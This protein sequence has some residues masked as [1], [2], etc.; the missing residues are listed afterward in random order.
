MAEDRKL[1]VPVYLNQ[2]I[3]FDMLAMLQ[4]GISTVTSVS[5]TE[6]SADEKSRKM[7]GSFGLSQALSS[8]LKIDLSADATS[9][10][11]GSE[12]TRRMEERF[13]TPASLF[14]TLRNLLKSQ[15]RLVIDRP[16]VQPA[17]GDIV[18]FQSTL[19]RNPLIETMDAV[20]ALMNLAEIFVQPQ[21]FQQGKKGAPKNESTRI[22]QQIESFSKSL[23][24]GDSIDLTTDLLQSKYKAIITIETQ[25]LNDPQMLDLV[26]GRFNVLG[27][28][29]RSI[30][31]DSEAISLIRRSPVSRMPASK[32]TDMFSKLELSMKSNEFDF[33]KLEWEVRGPVIQ[34]IPVAIFS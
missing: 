13:H 29:I 27:K 9:T 23:K 14:Y 7:G 10:K 2:R 4:G 20:S 6:Q 21:P 28:V 30:P 31:G 8:L 5:K 33:P 34:V 11:A 24:E 26:D 18:E 22:K 19:K 3:V 1:L 12:E 16:E 15:E 32:L 17:S 25:F